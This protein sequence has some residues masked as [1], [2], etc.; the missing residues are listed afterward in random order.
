IDIADAIVDRANAQK[1]PHWDDSAMELINGCT[2]DAI[3]C[4]EPNLPAV[5]RR[6]MQP[7]ESFLAMVAA[8]QARAPNLPHGGKSAYY[9]LAPFTADNREMQSIFSTARRHAKF[10]DD[11]A[12]IR[13]F[14]PERNSFRL[15][16]IATTPTTLYIGL[17]PDKLDA[18]YP[19]WVR[20]M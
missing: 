6:L 11:R 12:L 15:A 5:R 3:E 9:F 10:V 19:R 17:P 4:G 7:R 13:H 2:A 18:Y 1:D 14:T 8:A 20:V 16:D